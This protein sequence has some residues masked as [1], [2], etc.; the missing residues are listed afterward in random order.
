VV[1]F[2]VQQ[3]GHCEAAHFRTDTPADEVKGQQNRPLG[4][5]WTPLKGSRDYG[6]EHS[7]SIKGGEFLT[8]LREYLLLKR[9]PAPGS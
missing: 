2:T 6:K 9:D 5:D 4:V 8:Q 7:G 3:R 1:Y